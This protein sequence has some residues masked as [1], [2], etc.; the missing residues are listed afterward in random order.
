[1]STSGGFKRG[2]QVRSDK[3]E[4]EKESRIVEKVSR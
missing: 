2:R 1:L 3:A 4:A